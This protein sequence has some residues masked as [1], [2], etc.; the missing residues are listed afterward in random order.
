VKRFE[1]V[2]ADHKEFSTFYTIYKLSKYNLWFPSTIQNS[3]D[4]YYKYFK[5]DAFWIYYDGKRIGGVLLEPNWFGLV[6]LIP[7]FDD[8]YTLMNEIVRYVSEISDPKE[9][10]VAF[11][12][13]PDS[14]KWLQMFGFELVKT[15]KDMI[16]ATRS[17][18]VKFHDNVYVDVPKKG[19]L[20]EIIK[21]YYDVYSKSRVD[22]LARKP[23]E[24]YDDLLKNQIDDILPEYSTILRDAKTNEIIGCCSVQ[25]WCGLPTILDIIVKQSHQK[26][27]LA[28]MMIKKVLNVA[29][30]HEYPAVCL[31][32][33]SGNSAE[34]LY[35]KVGFLSGTSS[36]ELR[37]RL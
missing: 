2:K 18:E 3:I 27:G 29:Y 23:Y 13:V 1:F 7:P 35:H 5:Q 22:S 17:Y 28:T 33:V 6:F 34:Y 25:I 8:E 14:V 16:C 31:S 26:R 36:S 30:H 20:K 9:Y 24:F 12:M 32:V 15:Q 21:L 4:L 37:L 19:D 10:I 11:G